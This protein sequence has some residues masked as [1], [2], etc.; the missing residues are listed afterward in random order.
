MARNVRIDDADHVPRPVVAIGNEYPDGHVIA[1]HE[2]RR[3][4]LLT[5]ASGV[6][7][8]GT[9]NS[10]WVMPPQRGMWIP[11]ATRHHV[12]VV[13]SVEMQSLYLEP[14]ASIGLPERCEVVA[15]SSFMRSLI[16][17]ALEL[18]LEYDAGGRAGALMELIHHELRQL[19]ILP[20]SLQYPSS[21]L[22]A[23]RCRRFIE[24][25]DIHETIDGWSQELGISRR[26]FTRQFRRETGLSFVAW[27]QQACLLCAL[28]RL[29]AGESVTSV[30]ID[31]GY[32]NPAAFTLMFK[33]AFGAPPLAYLG[34]RRARPSEH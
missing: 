20:L 34:L 1:P 16:A 27:R 6:I 15:I 33:N 13:G 25:P 10:T 17:E 2:H 19:P 12:R 18:P 26:S 23:A 32:E 7:V 9:A 11:P 29:A 14:D 28:P 5:G 8:F 31:M 21:G 30:A 4:Q 24:K 22:L 3:G